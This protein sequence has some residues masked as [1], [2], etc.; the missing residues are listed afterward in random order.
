MSG[1]VDTAKAAAKLEAI[2]AI[3]REPSFT[4]EVKTALIEAYLQEDISVEGAQSTQL[5]FIVG[6]RAAAPAEARSE[7][8]IA[9]KRDLIAAIYQNNA[10]SPK[11]KH[12][13]VQA[14]VGPDQPNFVQNG[15][16]NAR[17]R[18]VQA[19]Y[20]DNS[21]S[22]REK[23][24]R[25]QVLME[26]K[27]S[28]SR[29][30]TSRLASALSKRR[31]PR[32]SVDFVSMS[33]DHIDSSVTGES[34][35]QLEQDSYFKDELS[36]DSRSHPSEDDGTLTYGK[37]EA[38]TRETAS[39]VVDTDSISDLSEGEDNNRRLY[40]ILFCA[41]VLFWVI[42]GPLLGTYWDEITGNGDAATIFEA[43]TLSPTAFT[44]PE[45][46]SL[47]HFPPST[48]QCLRISQGNSVFGEE[49]M[50]LKSFRLDVD[51]TLNLATNDASS[52]MSTIAEAMQRILAPTMAGCPKNLLVSAQ[53][54]RG[55]NRRQLMKDYAVGNVK[56]DVVPGSNN[57]NCAQG[58][59][60]SACFRM[61]IALEL[62]MKGYESNLQVINHIHSIFGQKDLINVLELSAPFED[63]EV[64]NVLATAA[65]T[66]IP[67][68]EPTLAPTDKP[69]GFA[70]L[71]PTRS[72]TLSPTSNTLIPT[73]W[74]TNRPTPAPQTSPP[75]I[76]RRMHIEQSLRNIPL[77]NVEAYD[78]LFNADYWVPSRLYAETDAGVW[79]D[80]YVL[81]TLFYTSQGGTWGIRNG[82]GASI[83]HCD[84]VGVTC[85]SSNNRVSGLELRENLMVG[86]FPR[87]LMALT[88]LTVLD[89][90]QN[91]FPG[92]VPTEIG[93][94]TDLQTL[95][96]STFVI[97]RLRAVTPSTFQLTACLNLFFADGV[98]LTGS[99]PARIGNLSNLKV[100]DLSSNAIEASI[101][102]QVGRMTSLQ[103]F[104]L[105]NNQLSGSIPRRVMAMTNLVFL[106][107]ANN[108]FQFNI[109]V[110]VE[111]LTKLQ[112]LRLDGNQLSGFIPALPQNLIDCTLAGNNFS[113]DIYSLLRGCRV[114]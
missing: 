81:M 15:S 100:F 89:L 59:K 22:P 55:N 74:P 62:Y 95:N 96:L 97:V 51:V 9:T 91:S 33:P 10:L 21:L 65:T 32:P 13:R 80:R 48:N 83:N 107:L 5:S 92:A 76:T 34:V 14:L 20:K 4:A 113:E 43:S 67:T 57:G 78:W 39:G 82:W 7:S 114:E 16:T 23:L 110:E 85:H 41:V 18:A 35:S 19:I 98:G 29:S 102:T 30:P 44:T 24:E 71:T 68:K 60:D 94:M 37:S 58:S 25:V 79:V 90:S 17:G 54:V 105:P 101:P 75:T 64:I 40:I 103:T 49:Q 8:E 69:T 47:V 63:V 112:I 99:L 3:N 27:A 72:P 12:Q 46:T 6:S 88:K 53:G 111:N 108:N 28:A 73:R 38:S 84:W 70:T 87:E 66:D 42:V 31:R 109:P 50:D 104:L 93:L 77:T 52:L 11:E 56:I 61:K 2:E 36:K 86:T 106:G 26:G 45:P 1:S